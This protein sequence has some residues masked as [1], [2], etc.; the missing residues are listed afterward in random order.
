LLP[1]LSHSYL[2]FDVINTAPTYIIDALTLCYFIQDQ[3]PAA[4]GDPMTKMT[5]HVLLTR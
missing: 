1:G 5:R 2:I 3:D 4:F